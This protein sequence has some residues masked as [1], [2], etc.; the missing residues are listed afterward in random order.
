MTLQLMLSYGVHH[1][2]L[3]ILINVAS[4]TLLGWILLKRKPQVSHIFMQ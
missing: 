3:Y 4:S 1:L 2:L